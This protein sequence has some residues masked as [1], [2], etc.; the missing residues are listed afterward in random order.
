MVCAPVG[1]GL[2]FV[3][4]MQSRPVHSDLLMSLNCVKPKHFPQVADCILPFSKASWM[5]LHHGDFDKD[6][7]DVHAQLH[8][9]VLL[10][11]LWDLGLHFHA[12]K[13]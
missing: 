6:R 8:T 12:N 11:Y 3:P 10:T 13:I 7:H 5:C 9:S 2:Q 1:Q 4:L